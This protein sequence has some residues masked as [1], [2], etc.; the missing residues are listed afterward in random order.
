[1]LRPGGLRT[2]RSSPQW[3]SWFRQEWRDREHL[4]ADA[5]TRHTP[6]S[7]LVSR[8]RRACVASSRCAG[9][10][11]PTAD[12]PPGSPTQR[13]I[14][15]RSAPSHDQDR[16]RLARRGSP[17]V[18]AVAYSC[19]VCGSARLNPR[20]LQVAIST[21]DYSD[22]VL[23]RQLGRFASTMTEAAGVMVA[24][25][26]A[27]RRQPPRTRTGWHHRGLERGKPDIDVAASGAMGGNGEAALRCDVRPDALQSVLV[28]AMSA[29]RESGRCCARILPAQ[30]DRLK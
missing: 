15:R 26:D 17:T 11:F 4:L 8:G 6:W 1:V 14:A 18:S 7:S 30:C 20:E 27:G 19:L 24:G 12:S 16:I 9:S 2:P 13:S 23:L 5:T 22:A 29:T 25:R 10:R 28:G 3:S 21:Y